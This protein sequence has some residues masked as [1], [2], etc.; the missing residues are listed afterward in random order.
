V[1]IFPENCNL[2]EENVLPVVKILPVTIHT[3]EFLELMSALSGQHSLQKT[4]SKVLSS[5]NFLAQ[6]VQ[7]WPKAYYNI[8]L[9]A[10]SWF[11]ILVTLSMCRENDCFVFMLHYSLSNLPLKL[12]LFASFSCSNIYLVSVV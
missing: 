7:D 6:I 12:C 9:S 4:H 10:V 5:E 8:M 11:T 2:S 1:I 3:M